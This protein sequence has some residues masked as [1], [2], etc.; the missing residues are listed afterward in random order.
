MSPRLHGEIGPDSCYLL[1]DTAQLMPDTLGRIVGLWF[2]V[3][4]GPLR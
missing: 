1:F 2:P 3:I 4:N